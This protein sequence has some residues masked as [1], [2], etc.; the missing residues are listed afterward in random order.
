MFAENNSTLRHNKE[1]LMSLP[2]VFYKM[3]VTDFIPCDCYY[4]KNPDFIR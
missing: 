3:A 2:D 4:P 1:K